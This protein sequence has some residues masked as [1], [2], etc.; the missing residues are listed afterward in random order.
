MVDGPVAMFKAG[1][2]IGSYRVRR[3]LGAGGMGEVFLAE[4]RHIDRKAA[5]KVLRPELSSNED[6]VARFFSEARSAS[7]IK[8]PGIV[9]IIDCEIDQR[10]RAYIVMELLDGESLGQCLERVGNLE[11]NSSLGIVGQ[12][13][14]ALSAAHPKGIIHRDLK[15]DNV[16]LVSTPD[17]AE[18]PLSVKV[19]D[20]GIAKLVAH[21]AGE[22]GRTRTGSLLGTPLYMSPE[23][24]RGAGKV[25]HRTDIYS[26]G[27]ILFEMLAGRPPFIRDGAGE[28]IAAHLSEAPPDILSLEPSLQPPLGHLVMRMLAKDPDARPQTMLD[29][30]QAVEAI[31]GLPAAQ[32]SKAIRPPEGFPPP[33]DPLPP[34][35]AAPPYPSGPES[36][37]IEP[38]VGGTRLLPE[39]TSAKVTTFSTTGHRVRAHRG[40][41]TL[42]PRGR[43]VVWLVAALLGVTAVGVFVFVP[44]NRTVPV[45]HGAEPEQGMAGV[46]PVQMPPPPRPGPPSPLPARELPARP[47]ASP[48]GSDEPTA[49]KTDSATSN[50]KHPLH[51]R[52]PAHSSGENP[53][54]YTLIKEQ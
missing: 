37:R 23:Q 41:A 35:D 4:H 19:L 27:C 3:R 15:P 1:D 10:G 46:Q 6:V 33:A 18:T 52:K 12:I 38:A 51:K 42:P 16:F 11:L 48:H 29:V 21:D 50:R 5:I 36:P 32:F 22:K 31:L 24:C 39:E 20:F 28:L 7:R 40:R 53:D 25:D 49:Q 17:D 54:P 9:E 44:R 47:V 14:S 34:I 13:A 45:T 2:L 8:H 43:R 30:V 26:L